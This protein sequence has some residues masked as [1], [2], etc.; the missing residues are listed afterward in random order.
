MKVIK[1]YLKSQFTE[2]E[3]KDISK[4]LAYENKNYDELED[5]KKSV[6]S[7]FSSKI[8]SSRA[9]ISKLSNNINNGYEYKDVECEIR[10]NE[11]R[12]GQKTTVRKDTGEIVRIEDMNER[13]LQE[14]LELKDAEGNEN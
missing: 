1:E 9:I 11:P 8:N 5:A 10:L 4:K 12:D 7:E 2:Q 6:T 14:E 3:L 13:E